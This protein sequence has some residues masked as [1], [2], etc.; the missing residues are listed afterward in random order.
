MNGREGDAAALDG[1]GSVLSLLEA[2]LEEEARR[3][4]AENAAD[5]ALSLPGRPPSVEAA[6]RLLDASAFDWSRA[7]APAG[8]DSPRDWT[9]AES[10][11][12]SDGL[13]LAAEVAEA[14]A[15]ASPS[16]AAAFKAFAVTLRTRA[17]I[18]PGG[19]SRSGWS[20]R[21]E[22]QRQEPD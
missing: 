10:E 13:R 16:H 7:A 22:Q 11:R 20:A 15:A 18:G 5:L 1:N 3:V 6:F 2:V 17:D 9:T 14:F 12:W 4:E 19:L 21:T 8:G